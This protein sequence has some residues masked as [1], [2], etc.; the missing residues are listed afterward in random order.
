MVNFPVRSV[1]SGGGRRLVGSRRLAGGRRLTGRMLT[2]R[3]LA[4]DGRLAG[5]AVCG[6]LANRTGGP[7]IV[8]HCDNSGSPTR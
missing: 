4:G 3:R 2:G 1:I 6:D 8:A 5:G 7:R